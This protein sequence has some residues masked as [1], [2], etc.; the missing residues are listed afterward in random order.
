MVYEEK[1]K[2]AKMPIFSLFLYPNTHTG[3][4]PEKNAGS[5]LPFP[6]PIFIMSPISF[7]G[8]LCTSVIGVDVK[9]EGE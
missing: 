9:L 3:I 5:S 4:T 6:S 2:C 8:L 1:L 7:V